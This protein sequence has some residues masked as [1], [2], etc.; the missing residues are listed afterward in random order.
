MCNWFVVRNSGNIEKSFFTTLPCEQHRGR[1]YE[2]D[3]NSLFG[4]KNLIH[5]VC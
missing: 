5:A 4:T 3:R 2:F 1:I